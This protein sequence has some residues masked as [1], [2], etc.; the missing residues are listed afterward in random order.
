MM[1]GHEGM[2]ADTIDL[3]AAPVAATLM[4][5]PLQDADV[6]VFLLDG[7]SLHGKLKGLDGWAAELSVQKPDATA[8]TRIPFSEL[9]YLAFTQSYPAPSAARLSADDGGVIPL[10]SQLQDYRIEFRDGETMSGQARSSTV[11][12]V[13][14]HV[15]KGADD[16]R[17]IR[18]FIPSCAVAN[19]RFGPM[20]GELLI[21]EHKAE[22]SQVDSALRELE[23]RHKKKIGEYLLSEQVVSSEQ[24][25]QLL[26]R[27]VSY[28]SHG[29][30]KE[31]VPPIG[32]LLLDDK[33]IT[34]AQLDDALAAQTRDR[35][36][37]LGEILEEMGVVSSQA[38]QMALAQKFGIAM[39]NLRHFD[40]DPDVLELLPSDIAR[41]HKVIPLFNYRGRLVVSIADPADSD[42]LD[43]I[44]FITGRNIEVTTASPQD[45]EWA[46]SKHYGFEEDIHEA[47]EKLQV[48][49]V[50]GEETKLNPK[51]ME[52]L[53]R[54]KP[55]VRLVNRFIID[56]IE[57][58]ASDIHIHAMEDRVD[59]IMR[60]DGT[61]IH[62]RSFNKSLLPA[63]VSRIKIIGNMDIVERRLPQDGGSRIL[64][65]GSIVD[66]RISIIPTVT[67]ESVVI[68][69]LNT[70]VGVK[71]LQD[72]GF[73]DHDQ[74]VLTDM[75]H[76]SNG[77]ALVTG[78]TGSGKSTTL[79][80]ALQEIRAQNVNV[81]TV[82]DPV[83]YH[84]SG[85]EQ[86][87]ANPAT[88]LTF[89]RALRHI[90]RHDPDVI[91][92]GEI[93]DEETAKMA[94]ESALTGHLVLSTLHTNDAASTVTRLLEMGVEPYLLTATLLGVLAQRLVRLN[95]PHCSAPEAVEPM[96]RKVLG[97]AD[98][99]VFYRGKG[100]DYCDN[101]GYAGRMAVY[102]LL[103]VTPTLRE[104]VTTG[105][106]STRLQDQAIQEGMVPLTQNALAQARQR[107]IPLSEVY[108]VRLQ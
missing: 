71:Q 97:V 65:N 37:K 38:I 54:E 30:A 85:V 59:L 35:G 72:L 19:Y 39:V 34:Q 32:K 87:Q 77:I 18:L 83:E 95:C 23:E 3:P 108:R 93:R 12:H 90:L 101:T 46:L 99:E 68:R 52:Q 106:T 66:L 31:E 15:F 47:E 74:E 45:I 56:A 60:I 27:Q 103:Q 102:E 79:Y 70:Q 28:M 92:V 22:P 36:K 14:L 8:P 40:L 33:L 80:A 61:L 78:P 25:R 6:D 88:G 86:I 84:I 55:I 64:H 73:N 2:T 69:L 96:V 16:D 44:R 94:V 17:V 58:K 62:L 50:L 89:A 107:K 7:E 100:C 104:Q 13:G 1:T 10:T 20:L 75:L 81:I 29:Y 43:M 24:L 49:Q 11:D 82:E 51:E 4:E 63:V 48:G 76:R 91:M 53:G 5:A 42:A 98:D 41:K 21:R 57:K 26:E 67:G 105:V 9:R